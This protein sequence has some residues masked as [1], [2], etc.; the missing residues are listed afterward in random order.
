M[1]TISNSISNFFVSTIDDCKKLNKQNATDPSRDPRLKSVVLR[2]I[3]I[4][5]AVFAVLSLAATLTAATP[6]GLLAGLYF[7]SVY[8]VLSHDAIL[9]GNRLSE[10]AHAL[11][12]VTGNVSSDENVFT[13]G[14]KAVKTLWNESSNVV[15]AAQ[16]SDV[17]DS[18]SVLLQGTVL[19]LP[20]YNMLRAC[21]SK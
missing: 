15:N 13:A 14:V 4:A 1:S 2:T 21:F 11:D 5:A 19:A 17:V 6:L 16:Q 8:V 20:V 3:G 9:V 18:T 10:R 7:T 12:V